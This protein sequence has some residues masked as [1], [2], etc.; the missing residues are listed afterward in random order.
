MEIKRQLEV[1]IYM[2]SIQT[3][4]TRNITLCQCQLSYNI[5]H[6]MKSLRTSVKRAGKTS[7]TKRE[8]YSTLGLE[9]AIKKTIE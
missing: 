5:Y 7:Y 8:L 2:P 4:V 1:V 9:T 3:N 6:T